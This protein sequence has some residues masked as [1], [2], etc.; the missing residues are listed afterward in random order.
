MQEP[1]ASI[2][3]PISAR[4]SESALRQQPSQ[5]ASQLEQARNRRS[6]R[7]ALTVDCRL[8]SDSWEGEIIL[9]ATDISNEGLWVE[10]PCVLARG[11]ELVVSFALPNAPAERV[12]AIAEVARVGMW[13]RRQ[14]PY[15]P[16]MGLVFTYC[17]D[18][19]KSRLS[20]SLRGR[21]P[22]LP[23]VRRPPPLPLPR[24]SVVEDDEVPAV[25]QGA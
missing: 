5:R 22:R 13:R 4:A 21:P 7:R 14:D 6:L 19:D 20:A 9:P 16:G 10:T 12:W 23:P 2:E 11:E 15:P 1:Q 3:P 25:L 24:A 17:S 18:E 8:E